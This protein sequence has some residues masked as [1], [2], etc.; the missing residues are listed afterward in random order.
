MH[1]Q[2]LVTLLLARLTRKTLTWNQRI[3]QMR[4][5]CASRRKTFPEPPL[6]MAGKN[7]LIFTAIHRAETPGPRLTVE[8]RGGACCT[9][10]RH[11]KLCECS[12]DASR[13]MD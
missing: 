3:C 7:K 12:S 9:V 4:R 8:W 5:V 2:L 1:Q 11:A 6:N 10:Y 13:E